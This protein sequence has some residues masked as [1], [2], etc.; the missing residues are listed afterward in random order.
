MNL[1]LRWKILSFELQMILL[2]HLADEN[3]EYGSHLDQRVSRLR[4]REL[5]RYARP[6]AHDLVIEN[7][8]AV[9]D[10][11]EFQIGGMRN[12]VADHMIVTFQR[13][14]ERIQLCICFQT[15]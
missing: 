6:G 4:R 10:R 7:E 9:F 13:A 2:A 14:F 12:Q 15:L 1:K 3:A 5:A 8:Q 11:G